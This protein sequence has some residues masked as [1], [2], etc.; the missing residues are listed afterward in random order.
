MRTVHFRRVFGVHGEVKRDEVRTNSGILG[1]FSSTFFRHIESCPDRK[2]GE[3]SPSRG[4]TQKAMT[5]SIILHPPD[6]GTGELSSKG[7][8]YGSIGD[9]ESTGRSTKMYLDTLLAS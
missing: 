1:I 6:A 9:A 7:P 2:S 8:S 3:M 4:D 5:K